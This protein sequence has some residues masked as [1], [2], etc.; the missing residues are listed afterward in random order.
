MRDE[1]MQIIRR[2]DLTVFQSIGVLEVVKFELIGML[3]FIQDRRE[4]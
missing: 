1:I 3:P 2:Y 4:S